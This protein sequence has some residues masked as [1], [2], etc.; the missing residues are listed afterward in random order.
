MSTHALH[1]SPFAA[2]LRVLAHLLDYPDAALREHLPDLRAALH[3]QRTLGAER[4]AEI[5]ALFDQ[6]LDASGLDAEAA[7]VDLFDRGRGTALHLFEHVHGDSRDRGPAMIDLIKTYEEAGLYLASGELPD[8][9]TVA[10]E[11]ASTQPPGP[12]ADFLREIAHILRNIFS[13]LTRRE[14]AYAG[15]LAAL[16]DLAGEPTKIVEVPVEPNLDETWSEP[17]AFGGC[18]SDGQRSPGEPQPVR[19]V[20]AS[21][22]SQPGQS[23][24]GAST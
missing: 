7:Y 22:Q 6:L 8:H 12:A 18:S 21:R 3:A 1:S 5:D 20:K 16:L 24:H 14:S 23:A 17:A 11:Y 2:T 19:I 13:A 9:L 4:L 15:V 10:L